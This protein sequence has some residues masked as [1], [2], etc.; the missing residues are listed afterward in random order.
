[1]SEISQLEMLNALELF[2]Y[3]QRFRAALFV[4]VLGEGTTLENLLTD[5]RVLHVS[6]V[7]VILVSKN[8]S[9]LSAASEKYNE[10]TSTNRLRP[11]SISDLN[12]AWLK[13]TLTDSDM[14]LVVL[15][16][17]TKGDLELLQQS[18]LIADL[19]NADRV[20]LLSRNP[21]LVVDHKLLSHCSSEELKEILKN[22]RNCNISLEILDYLAQQ[23]RVKKREYALLSGG[24]GELFTEVFTHRGSGTLFTNVY[25][26]L[27][28]RAELSDVLEIFRLMKPY[29]DSGA[30]R[31]ITEDEVAA[32][33]N[34]YQV[35][36]VNDSIVASAQ[37]VRYGMA[38]EIAK[39][40][41]LPRYQGKGRARELAK[42]L[43]RTAQEQEMEF[44]FS[45]SSSKKMWRFFDSLGFKEIPREKLPEEWKA[46]YDFTRISK[47]FL[48]ELS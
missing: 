10:R 45:L 15:P 43:M 40:A 8:S 33:I 44:V 19:A 12:P 41:T 16:P 47:A 17:D 23:E 26:N 4:V 28:R 2:Q 30:M 3:S 36:I 46:Q 48:R 21:G 6:H 5:L 24:S 25:S 20:F 18:D 31:P 29:L 11:C 38:G 37:L 39:F 9:E 7:S 1:M 34:N 42:S 14:P 27:I 13:K 32:S 22:K 35:Y